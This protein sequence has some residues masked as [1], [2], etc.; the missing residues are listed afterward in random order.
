MVYERSRRPSKRGLAELLSVCIRA[1]EHQILDAIR[2]SSGELNGDRTRVQPRVEIERLM[3]Q[4]GGYGLEI[5]DMG[6]KRQRSHVALGQ[7]EPPPVVSNQ[8]AASTE[9]LIP[10][11]NLWYLPLELEV[12][13]RHRWHDYQWLAVTHRPQ[14]DID[15]VR[16]PAV[17][18][19]R[20]HRPDN[21]SHDR[22]RSVWQAQ[23]AASP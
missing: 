4:S 13:P 18:N 22:H 7:P 23:H 20:L 14:C 9:G 1:E 11:A 2:P 6:V 15:A 19:E 3:T 17:L 5:K 12:A 8:L 21:R 10:T 16:R